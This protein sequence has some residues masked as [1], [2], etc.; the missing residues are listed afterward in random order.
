MRQG[1]A[2][3]CFPQQQP[4]SPCCLKFCCV[5][6]GPGCL[7]QLLCICRSAKPGD[8]SKVYSHGSSSLK[9]LLCRR[10]GGMF[11][12]LPLSQSSFPAVQD[13]SLSSVTGLSKLT[14]LRQLDLAR[15]CLTSLGQLSA[16]HSLAHLSIEGNQLTSLAG[17][18]CRLCNPRSRCLP[19]TMPCVMST[20]VAAQLQPN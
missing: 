1:A 18:L 11:C 2:N 9:Q 4:H 6:A 13:N 10:D 17:A 7:V 8:P 12:L 16:L 3:A 20:E 15:N 19:L 14:G 5:T